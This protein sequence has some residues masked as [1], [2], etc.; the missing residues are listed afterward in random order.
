[1]SRLER[2]EIDCAAGVGIDRTQDVVVEGSLVEIGVFAVG[3]PGKQFPGQLE[4][5]VG[6]AG[7]L[8]GHAEPVADLALCD[9]PR[10]DD[11]EQRDAGDD[12]GDDDIAI[13][14]QESGE[15]SVA[16]E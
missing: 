8:G 1:M 5:V 3:G 11:H 15:E 2:Q 10:G 4:H 13:D 7:F 12:D 9:A 16:S 6:I 14:S